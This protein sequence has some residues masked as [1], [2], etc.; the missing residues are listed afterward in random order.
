M[1]THGMAYMWRSEDGFFGR[2]IFLLLPLHG[3]QV[4]V[5]QT[6]VANTFTCWATLLAQS[7]ISLYQLFS[8]SL[9]PF[10]LFRVSQF[11]LTGWSSFGMD[12][13]SKESAWKCMSR[14]T[15]CSN[16]GMSWGTKAR[17][18]WPSHLISFLVLPFLDLRSEFRR[19]GSCPHWAN[20]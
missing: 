16:N 18:W 4:S 3:L 20:I 1:T 13:Q 14:F 11:R 5:H 6:S 19:E 2:I 12:L 17:G 15:R 8:L 9:P 7:S 10:L